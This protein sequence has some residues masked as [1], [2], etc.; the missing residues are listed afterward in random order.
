ME[1]IREFFRKTQPFKTTVEDIKEHIATVSLQKT[2]EISCSIEDAHNLLVTHLE[3]FYKILD[4][5]NIAGSYAMGFYAGKMIEDDHK[6]AINYKIFLDG[7]I[8]IV[9]LGNHEPLLQEIIDIL[10]KILIEKIEPLSNF[11][12]E[13]SQDVK[14]NIE[15]YS[16]ESKEACRDELSEV[17][18]SIRSRA[19]SDISGNGKGVVAR[20]DHVEDSVQ[21]NMPISETV[22]DDEKKAVKTGVV[23]EIQENVELYMSKKEFGDDDGDKD[24]LKMEIKEKIM[25]RM[26]TLKC[27]QIISLINEIFDRQFIDENYKVIAE[28]LEE[29]E[30]EDKLRIDIE[31]DF[32]A[33]SSNKMSGGDKAG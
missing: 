1:D 27:L 19:K 9:A 28:A 25:E 22:R 17:I 33:L 15:K 7:K 13:E 18:S 24:R 31:T 5:K 6:F 8:L 11:E 23:S 20:P 21:E 30:I 10:Q 14:E 4:S 3:H 32:V 29:L 26:R 12:R 2:F 16:D